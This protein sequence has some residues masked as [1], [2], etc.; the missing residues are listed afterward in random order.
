MVHM[1]Y[2]TELKLCVKN[3]DHNFLY[4]SEI[5][6][7]T[8]ILWPK[9]IKLESWE[10]ILL[11]AHQSTKWAQRAFTPKLGM[12]KEKNKKARRICMSR[13]SGSPN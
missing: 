2:D 7:N 10:T 8:W 9:K 3:N 1:F 12:E 4:L 5:K 6:K 13:K 11:L